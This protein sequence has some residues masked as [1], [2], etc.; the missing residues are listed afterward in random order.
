M[1]TNE[2]E[3]MAAAEQ[4]L[5]AKIVKQVEYYFSDANLKRDHFFQKEILKDPEG[6]ISMEVLLRCNKLKQLTEDAQVVANAL[7]ASEA[8]SV[9]EDAS[10]VKKKGDVPTLDEDVAARASKKDDSGDLD[11][12]IKEKA[13][14]AV[15]DRLV[16]TLSGLPA[17]CR[18]TD[19]KDALKEVVE[20]QG[21][22]HVSHEDGETGAHIT[23]FAEGNKDAW[24]TAAQ[25]GDKLKVQDAVI[26]MQR[27]EDEAK[28][29][30]FWTTEFTK[31][32]PAT[33]SKDK[34]RQ[35][36]EPASKKRQAPATTTIDF[37]GTE[38][39]Y[40][41]LKTRVNE[42]SKAHTGEM[43]ELAGDEAEFIKALFEHHPRASEKKDKMTGVAVG[44][45]P[46]FPDT[47]CFFVVKEGDVKEDFS[48]KK[49]LD[50]AFNIEAGN[51]RA[52]GN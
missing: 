3:K 17:G 52:R 15:R 38:Y 48:Y 49:C 42:I 43:D 12:L 39:D 8:V 1:G 35:K 50:T 11:A 34:K 23:A 4:D 10:K 31:N 14:A 18:W 46:T 26:T 24:A 27:V 47:R 37:C 7:K 44:V 21:R 36:K 16:Y 32:P 28:L 22:M 5:D 25:L 19:I 33:D 2:T 6:Y 9:S 41:A 13:E 45:N 30:E 20:T 51:K 29:L 40:N